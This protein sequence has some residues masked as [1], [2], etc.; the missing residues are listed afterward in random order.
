MNSVFRDFI[1]ALDKESVKSGSLLI[2]T[3]ENIFSF[4]EIG[5]KTHGDLAEIGISQFI[6]S[7]LKGWSSKHVGK[8]LYRAK[9]NEEDI[10]VT[11]PNGDKLSVSIKAYGN[12]PLQL[13]T[14]KD[15]SMF[16]CLQSKLGNNDTTDSKLISEILNASEFQDFSSIN[17]LP[18]IY[19]EKKNRCRIMVFDWK[20]AKKSVKKIAFVTSKKG[21][22]HPVYV[23]TDADQKYL[24]EVRYGDKKANALQRGL[25]TNSKR[26]EDRFIKVTGWVTY[27]INKVLLDLVSNLLVHESKL[28][29][30]LLTLLKRR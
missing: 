11:S 17:V 4:R 3:L 10:E 16:R 6:N 21:R 5:N 26:A 30:E 12:G 18:L 22:K 15:S 28:H 7:H 19:D 13:S 25:W 2:R 24:F 1:I 29:Q 27:N 23:F 8:S 9:T 20:T 14:N